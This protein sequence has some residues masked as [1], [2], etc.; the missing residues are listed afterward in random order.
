MVL[1]HRQ[2]QRRGFAR[3]LLEHCLNKADE[4]G[5]QTIKLD[6]TD[7]GWPIYEKM[8]FRMEQTIQRWAGCLMPGATEALGCAER[9]LAKLTEFDRD[10]FGAD[11]TLLLTLLSEHANA[12]Q[13]SRGYLCYR[14][15]FRASYLGPCIA[16]SD[17]E[18]EQLIRHAL[19]RGGNWFWDI[20]EE[21]QP[22]RALA[23]AF[24]FSVQRTLRRMLRGKE[25]RQ[26]TDKIYAIAGFE[27]G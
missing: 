16:N 10:V 17:A 15:G 11:R 19:K 8:G 20:L 27:L 7:Q 2:Y 9:S 21:N 3:R 5:V 1:T 23:A 24:G 18:A 26:Q 4:L 25:H 13:T 12:F 14:P 22:A 6:A